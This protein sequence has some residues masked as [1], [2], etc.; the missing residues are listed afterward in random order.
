[1]AASVVRKKYNFSFCWPCW[2]HCRTVNVWHVPLVTSVIACHHLVRSYF[3]E[4]EVWGGS[5]SRLYRFPKKYFGFFLNT[6]KLS[7]NGG[8][9]SEL[10]GKQDGVIMI[11]QL[12][13]EKRK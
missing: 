5:F 3:L 13:V 12:Y 8:G 11:S 6:F 2:K 1:M 7:R 4:E 9:E 10:P